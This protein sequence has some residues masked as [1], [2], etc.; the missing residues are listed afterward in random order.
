MSLLDA[1]ERVVN[2]VPV[3]FVAPVPDAETVRLFSLQENVPYWFE[4][5]DPKPGWWHVIPETKSDAGLGEE[6]EIFERHEYLRQLPKFSVITL[7]PLSESVWLV[8]PFNESDAAQRGWKNS[9]PRLMH[10]VTGL[11]GECD[12]AMARDMGGTLLYDGLSHLWQHLPTSRE[13]FA[14]RIIEGHLIEMQKRQAEL[15]AEERKASIE[16]RARWQLEFMGATLLDWRELGSSYEVTW[17][18]EGA[19]WTM[20]LTRDLRIESAGIC[21][22]GTDRQHN[23]SSIVE[24]MKTGRKL[25]RYDMPEEYYT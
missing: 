25:K 15:E 1:F 11:P 9:S 24:I 20:P 7:F 5:R 12:T 2:H 19:T 16:D 8:V 22:A 4:L 21:L 10:L 13:L 17:E 14:R 3:E 23:L 6:V 18:H